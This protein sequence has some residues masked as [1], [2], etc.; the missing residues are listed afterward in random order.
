M[1]TLARR[2]GEAVSLIVRLPEGGSIDLAII[3]S[4]I[5]GGQVK[6][7]FDAP[8]EV[9]IVRDE[10]AQDTPSLRRIRASYDRSLQG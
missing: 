9:V 6:I 7:G 4:E 1:L 10:I 2:P 8:D 5:R 3:V